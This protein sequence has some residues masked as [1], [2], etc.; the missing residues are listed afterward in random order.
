MS[1]F[2]A[3]LKKEFTEQFRTNRVLIVAAIFLF[4]GLSTPLLVKYLPELIKLAG[5]GGLTIEMPPPTATQSMAEYTSTMAQ[6]GVLM[7][8]LVAMGAVAREVENGTA[9][10]V[11]S[12]PVGRLAFIITKLKASGFTF[13][14]AMVLGGLACWGY[15]LVLFGEAN[16]LGFLY[17]NLL[18]ALFFV[19]S[20]AVTLLFSSLFRSQLAA[21]ALALA[22]IIGG[23]LASA[24]PWVG[25]YLPGELISWGDALVAGRSG[26][27]GWGA[28]A[29]TA[30]LIG[31]SLY[32][33]WA[34]LRTKE[35]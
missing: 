24:L 22:S 20:L 30:T 23:S 17:Q 21:G 35:L 10:M 15:T 26:E 12:K 16:G 7:A 9:A 11:L 8:V 3:L 31:L 34:S 18:L 32:L 1:G 4:F 6:F 14:V 2:S 13:L 5:Q 29:V 33:A 25:R 28:V 27:S 19:L